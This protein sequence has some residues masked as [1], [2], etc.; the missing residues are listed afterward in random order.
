MQ[1]AC[2]T[3]A[4]Q[5]NDTQNL[6]TTAAQQASTQSE[7]RQEAAAREAANRQ[8]SQHE[9]AARQAAKQRQLEWWLIRLEAVKAEAITQRDY[10]KASDLIAE[11]AHVKTGKQCA[12]W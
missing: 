7:S 5:V 9:A 6:S 4:Q 11:I 12:P 1:H 2:K 10:A 8:A 3:Y